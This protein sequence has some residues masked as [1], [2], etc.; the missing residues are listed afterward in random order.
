MLNFTIFLSKFAG[1]VIQ[2]SNL[3]LQFLHISWDL[4]RTIQQVMI[5]IVELL[6]NSWGTFQF[7]IHF[8]RYFDHKSTSWSLQSVRISYNFEQSFSVSKLGEFFQVVLFKE[9]MNMPWVLEGGASHDFV[10]KAFNLCNSC[11]NSFDI[12]CIELPIFF[13]IR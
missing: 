4:V 12:F 7:L 2:K 6:S 3:L 13:Q 11:C 10:Q 5:Q 1:D 9:D 8:V